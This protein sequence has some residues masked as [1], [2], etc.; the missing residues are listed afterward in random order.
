MVD[1]TAAYERGPDS[2][3][4]SLVSGDRATSEPPLHPGVPGAEEIDGAGAEHASALLQMGAVKQDAGAYLEA[5]DLFRRALAIGERAL[6][7]ENP[8][9]VPAIT[10][11]ASAL[12][13]QARSE[14][15]RPLVERAL[16]VSETGPAQHDPDL[17]IVLNELARLCLKQSA[18][19]LAEPLLLRMFE[20]KR[21]KGED[22]PEVATVL[23]S[24]A[25]VRQALGRHEAAEQLWRRV[26]EIRERTLAPNH[27]ALATALEHLGEAC[28]AR[29]KI[30][31]ALQLLQRAQTIRELTLGAGH[32]SVRVSRERIADLQLQAEGSL[33]SEVL[34]PAPAPERYRLL[35]AEHSPASPPPPPTAERSTPV[36]RKGTARVMDNDPVQ[37]V[38][39]K[40]TSQPPTAAAAPARSMPEV[41]VL[42]AK[43][44]EAPAAA[45]SAAP[46]APVNFRDVIMSIRQELDE[47][48][49][50]AVAQPRAKV[51]IA[52]VVAAVKERQRA[53]AVGIVSIAT[54]VILASV[55]SAWS[56][57]GA[58]E[59]AGRA[60]EPSRAIAT[61]LIPTGSSVS[62]AKDAEKTP[63]VASPAP[64]P[65]PRDREEQR[66]TAKKPADRRASEGAPIS[67][68]KISATL[69]GN[70][71]SV[72]RA[73]TELSRAITEAGPTEPLP[74]TSS[75]QPLFAPGDAASAPQRAQLI[76]ALPTLRYPAQ[77]GNVEGEVRVRFQ[78]DSLG[79]PVTSSISVVRSSNSLFTAATLKVI[80]ELRF[81][82]ARTGGADSRPVSD[83][84]QIGFQFK[85][86][87]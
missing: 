7:M 84:V 54:L 83:V 40:L 2:P 37:S 64:T 3:S 35:S 1:S 86:T 70:F 17:A 36:Q 85:P 73:R 56:E 52:S 24:L 38:E 28:A 72:V 27:F 49:E 9:L 39:R 12:I 77:L 67:I 25:T 69:A 18:Y 60:A 55:S 32:Q 34:P 78:V 82:P 87:K 21:A 71:D 15:A 10:G 41:A 48:E 8:A 16:A 11:L 13:M 66:V 79:R 6:G 43:T 68:P 14:E 74:V 5:E 62:P 80:P 20:L 65:V 30:G 23:A 46:G 4:F 76:G 44:A 45:G 58:F 57:S 29:G 61:P 59:T 51:I 63:A 19:E 26:L 33:D 22:H 31:E 53:T 81:E 42:L 75:G 47:D 50:A